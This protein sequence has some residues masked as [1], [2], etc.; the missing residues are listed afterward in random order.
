MSGWRG[1]AVWFWGRP[2]LRS[3]AI[4][5]QVRELTLPKSR[6]VVEV[7]PQQLLYRCTDASWN[8]APMGK[9]EVMAGD[10]L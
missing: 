8:F 1:F 5:T 6:Y 4:E 2:V 3:L 7:T 10:Q 9:S